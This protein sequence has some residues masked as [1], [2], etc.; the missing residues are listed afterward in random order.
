MTN[1]QTGERFECEA[2]PEDI[3]KALSTVPVRLTVPDVAAIYQAD[4]RTVQN[5]QGKII[6]C[7]KLGALIR[8]SPDQLLEAEKNSPFLAK[9]RGNR[10][11]EPI[12]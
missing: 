8:F 11:L 12:K 1:L 10:R 4:E 7:M 9:R 5:W 2:R 3:V 6:P